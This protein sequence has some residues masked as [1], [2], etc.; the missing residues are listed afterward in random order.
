M[1]LEA[2]TS[3]LPAAKASHRL[4]GQSDRRTGEKE[5]EKGSSPLLTFID[6]NTYLIEIF[7]QLFIKYNT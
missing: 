2:K 3:G 1:V 4:R 5:K 7:C 6:Q